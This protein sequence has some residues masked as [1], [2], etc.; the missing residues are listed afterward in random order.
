MGFIEILKAILLGVVEGVT[1][2]LPI[3]STGH[4]ILVDEFAKLN[5]SDAFIDMFLYVIQ[6]GAILAVVYIFWHKLVPFSYKDNKIMIK[7]QT[8]I[9]WSKII[10]GCLPGFLVYLLFDNIVD[11]LFMNPL[12]VSA[13]LILYG[14]LF[15]VIEN[16]NKHRKPEV[17]KL[18]QLSYKTALLIGAFQALSI[19]PG[20]SRSGATIIGGMILG[21][22]RSVAAEYTFFMAVPVMFGISLLKIIKFGLVF[23]GWEVVILLVGMVTAF[24][25]SILA[26]KFLMTYIKKHDFKIFGWYRIVLG[27]IVIAYFLIAGKL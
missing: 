7:K 23:T 13:M 27:L 3:S 20:T 19:I 6:L 14:V 22:S 9:L 4:M 10:V 17:V 24:V 25:T 11:R 5:M 2:W 21:T 16:Y 26:I 15:I 18:S 8:M 1:E 12:T